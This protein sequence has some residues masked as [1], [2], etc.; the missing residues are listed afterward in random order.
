MSTETIKNIDQFMMN[1]II[2]L[3]IHMNEKRGNGN[4]SRQNVEKSL[5]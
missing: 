4:S 1:Y 2:P 5:D 3:K